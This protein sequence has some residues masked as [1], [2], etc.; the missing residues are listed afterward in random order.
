MADDPADRTYRVLVDPG[1]VIRWRVIP[2]A[3][4]GVITPAMCLPGLLGKSGN[5]LDW[6]FLPSG[7]M[8]IVMAVLVYTRR[9]IFCPPVE[10]GDDLISHVT[11]QI[12]TDIR[13]PDIDLDRSSIDG[14]RIVLFKRSAPHA[15]PIRIRIAAYGPQLIEDIRSRAPGQLSG[16][17][18]GAST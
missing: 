3:L 12:R 18:S 2:A 6:L 13:W 17:G 1:W 8:M 9:N 4:L 7:P 15:D 5:A 10:I 11:C 14:K 16:P